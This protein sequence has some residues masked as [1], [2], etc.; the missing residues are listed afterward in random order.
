MAQGLMTVYRTKNGRYRYD[1]N[2]K[3]ERYV[4]TGW[5][6]REAQQ[7]ED[8]RRQKLRARALGLEA[9]GPEDTPRF[10]D[11][12]AV[13]LKHARDRKKLTRVEQF[14]TNL[15]MVLGFFGA[16]PTKRAPVDGG[17]YKDLRLG[18]LVATPELLEEFEQW[19]D[20]LG[21]SGARKNHYRSAVSQMYRVALLPANRRKAGIRENPMSGVPRDR[22]P[23]RLKI[24][25]P[26]QLRAIIQHAAPHL[27]LALAIGALAPKLRLR[28]VL[29][30]RW[31][32][33]VADDLSYLIVDRHKTDK[34]TGLPL[35]API[36]GP[37]RE[38]LKAVKRRGGS[39]VIQYHGKPVK[40]IKTALRRACR[41]ASVKYG[42]GEIT[43]HS[44][45]HT[46]ATA[47]A[48]LRLP[49]SL[50]MRLMGH[51]NLSTTQIYT[52]L[53]A[54]DEAAP[55]EQLAAVF[56]FT[57]VMAIPRRLR[58]VKSSGTRDQSPRKSSEKSAVLSLRPTSTRA[59]GKR[60]KHRRAM[61]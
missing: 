52:H 27:Q 41:L 15:H 36:S 58:S 28:N 54:V 20:G 60:L 44:I 17:V 7:L 16:R 26:L 56:P 46:M 32:H 3:K 1:F 38:V 51:S 5:T 11:W 50:R 2:F 4:G 13:T 40:D 18:D 45:R 6:R 8:R 34:E 14:A 12:A 39:H 35:V 9:P 59:D 48:R 19:M 24:L 49:E 33:D 55:L 25:T 10:S 29:D 23:R 57:D 22:V 61:R 30:L 31:K 42:K 21:I 53:A 47:L 37:L 43:Y